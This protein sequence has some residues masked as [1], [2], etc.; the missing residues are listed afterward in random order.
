MGWSSVRQALALRFGPVGAGLTGYGDLGLER[1]TADDARTWTT[2]R[3]TAGKRSSRRHRPGVR[4]R[5]R[6]A[7]RACVARS[8]AQADRVRRVSVLL[9]QR[10]TGRASPLRARGAHDRV[11]D[12]AV[13][14]RAPAPQSPSLR[15]R[16]RVRGRGGLLPRCRSRSLTHGSVP[17]T[18]CRSLSS[19]SRRHSRC[20]TRW[21]QT[22]RPRRSSTSSGRCASGASA[23]PGAGFPHLGWVASEHLVGNPYLSRAGCA[24]G[25]HRRGHLRDVAA[26]FGRARETLL[27]VTTDE[28]C[29]A[30]GVLADPMF[31]PHELEGRRH[32][33]SGVRARLGRGERRALISSPDGVSVVYPELGAVTAR[34]DA[35]VLCIRE[36]EVRTLLS[37]D[38]FFVPVAPEAW[39]GG[40]KVIAEIDAAVPDSLVKSVDAAQDASTRTS[41]RSSGPPSNGRGWCRRNWSCS[42][43]CSTTARA[44]CCSRRPRRGGS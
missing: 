3:F 11:H 9:P 1:L 12:G 21:P 24:T 20:W 42:R 4:D 22:D 39:H 26:A 28:V 15:A 25:R 18:A 23:T 14:P 41:T 29:G 40:T 5:P 33:P 10:S 35:T 36:G 30:A 38:G 44:R 7:S 2:E 16:Y 19:G 8:R 6:A 13:D 37:D 27:V 31:S 34:Y 43:L 17:T 32:R